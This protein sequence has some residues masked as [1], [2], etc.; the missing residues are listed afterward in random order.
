MNAYQTRKT[1]SSKQVKYYIIKYV[2]N[3][4]THFQKRHKTNKQ[5]NKHLFGERKRQT[6]I[7]FQTL[8]SVKESSFPEICPVCVNQQCEFPHHICVGWKGKAAVVHEVHQ[9]P[10]SIYH[11]LVISQSFHDSKNQLE[12][13]VGWIEKSSTFSPFESL[14]QTQESSIC[15]APREKG[16]DEKGTWV[17]TPPPGH[18]LHTLRARMAPHQ[19]AT[20]RIL[21]VA[22]ILQAAMCT[23]SYSLSRGFVLTVFSAFAHTLSTIAVIHSDFCE[24]GDESCCFHLCSALST[25][26]YH[27]PRKKTTVLYP[28][29][30]TK[31]KH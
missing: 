31:E 24:D 27:R 25:N 3:L 13:K 21:H 15:T 16:Q 26:T 19:L 9:H 11:S 18:F 6:Q 28:L 2:G 17:K 1:F 30:S 5:T 4:K 23:T 14:L 8:C 22:E 20:S 29:S 7:V 12:W 10:V